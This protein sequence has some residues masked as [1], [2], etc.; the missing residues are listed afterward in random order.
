MSEILNTEQ[1]LLFLIAA[2]KIRFSL[3]QQSRLHRRRWLDW[4]MPL[5]VGTALTV[6]CQKARYATQ[7]VQDDLP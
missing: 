7:L 3:V 2:W 6:S 5:E 1:E 4:L